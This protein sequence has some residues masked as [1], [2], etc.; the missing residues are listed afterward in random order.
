[1]IPI[2][3]AVRQPVVAGCDG[4]FLKGYLSNESF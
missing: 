1:M 3:S 2:V 4:N